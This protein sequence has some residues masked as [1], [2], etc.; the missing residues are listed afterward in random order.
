MADWLII[1]LSGDPASVDYLVADDG[2]RI[3]EA[4]RSGSLA[5]AAQHAAGRRICVLA[6]ASDVLL[7]DA[8]VPV[9]SGTRVQQIVPY[10]LEEQVAQD[11]E[12]LHFA[13]GRRLGE[14]PR[15]PVAVVSRALVDGWL[16]QLREAGLTPECLYADS[17]LVPDNPGQAV[18]VLSG[19]NVI[20]R[21]SGAQPVTL[22]PGALAEA[23]ELLRPAPGPADAF[24][25]RGLVVY[26]GEAEWRECGAAIEAV[27]AYFEAL[28]VQLLPDGPLGLFAQSL[29]G[30]SAI[31]LLQG[32]Y[33]PASP[34]AGGLKAWRVAAAMALGLLV[35]H[36]IGSATQLL[37]LKRSER[38]LDQSIS[39]TFERAMPGEHNTS[40]A[41]RRMEARLNSLQGSADSS[42]LLAMLSAVAQARVGAAGTA[43]QAL[44]Y[45]DG[46]L[47]L[48]I[49]APGADALD[50]VSQQ[51]RT[52]GWQAELT[53]GTSSGGGY[54]GR[55][56]V[57]PAH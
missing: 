32:P 6:P 8:E 54:Q 50:H 55:I 11:I 48:Q 43:L 10:A 21:P 16:A 4:L 36:G 24:G 39:E 22:P 52:G 3:V 18:L 45:R 44:S 41:R 46:L 9:R 49:T 13:V 37:M 27:R 26:A 1:R 33:A 29:P 42:G 30:T 7:T 15:L 28:S 19:G 17:S 53:S 20:A 57:K 47:D 23:L 31:N 34:L 51:L 14:S 38:R 12:S 5:A 2:G 35:L 40:N 56:Q 25:G